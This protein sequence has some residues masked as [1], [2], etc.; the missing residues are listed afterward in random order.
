LELAKRLPNHLSH[1]SERLAGRP[2]HS[3]LIQGADNVLD[4]L[5]ER[6]DTGAGSLAKAV[7]SLFY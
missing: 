6:D 7:L 2:K 4:G 3:G 1:V 5:Q